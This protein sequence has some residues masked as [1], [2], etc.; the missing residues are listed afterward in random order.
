MSE[1][2]ISLIKYDGRFFFFF[3]LFNKT[4]W[5]SMNRNEQQFIL[6]L[7]R[8][9]WFQNEKRNTQQ[10]QQQLNINKKMKEDITNIKAKSNQKNWM[11]PSSIW[12]ENEE[13]IKNKKKNMNHWNIVIIIII[14]I[15]I[16]TWYTWKKI[17][18]FIAKCKQ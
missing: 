13:R 11:S 6:Q 18:M 2:F 1:S 16:H 10:Q 8:L 9:A 5:T 14:I 15:V 17:V 12:K 7:R 3:L 4:N